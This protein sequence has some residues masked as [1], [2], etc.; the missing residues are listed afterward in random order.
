[1]VCGHGEAFDPALFVDGP[2][3]VLSG[4]A[5]AVLCIPFLLHCYLCESRYSAMQL[6]CSGIHGKR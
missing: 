6:R 5:T 1:V 4:K 3:D 2:F